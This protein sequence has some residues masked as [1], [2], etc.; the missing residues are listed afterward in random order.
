MNWVVDA[1]F[2][3]SL[4]LKEQNSIQAENFFVNFKEGEEL[5]VPSLWWYEISNILIIS[6]R[7][8]RL[9]DTESEEAF[10]F[11]NQIKILTDSHHGVKS[12]HEIFKLAQ[13]HHLSSYDASYLETSKRNR[14]GLAT[15]DKSLHN[16]AKKELINLYKI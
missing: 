15:F 9:N 11:I 6:R 2:I 3:A 8:G 10:N 16:A 1:S 4:F 13:K 7:R 12:I 5:I 14:C